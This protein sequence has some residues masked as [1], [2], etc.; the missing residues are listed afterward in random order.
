[1]KKQTGMAIIGKML[2]NPPPALVDWLVVFAA[3]M[4]L[5]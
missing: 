4:L 1:M 2:A 5:I 3:D